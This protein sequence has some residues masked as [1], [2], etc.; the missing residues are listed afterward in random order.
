MR[1]ARIS[2]MPQRGISGSGAYTCATSASI[3]CAFSFPPKAGICVA[4]RPFATTFRASARFNRSRFSG[5]SAGP[6]PPNRSAPWQEAQCFGS[7][8]A[9]ARTT[10]AARTPRCR[11]RQQSSTPE[12]GAGREPLERLPPPPRRCQR[13]V[14]HLPQITPDPPWVRR[15]RGLGGGGALCLPLPT[16]PA[17]LRALSNCYCLP[18]EPGLLARAFSTALRR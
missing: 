8:R 9:S 18:G 5:S 4:S 11:Q 15:T 16:S 7:P 12:A 2:F 13:L 14:H 1:E 3:S 6:M 17:R 10:S